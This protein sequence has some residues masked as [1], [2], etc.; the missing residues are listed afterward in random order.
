MLPECLERGGLSRPS[1]GL[2]PAHA[3]CTPTLCRCLEGTPDYG[4]TL[5]SKSYHNTV[6]AVCQSWYVYHGFDDGNIDDDIGNDDDNDGDD[7][8]DTDNDDGYYD[9]TD[10]ES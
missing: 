2:L 4:S 10:D 1:S 7:H 5:H 6:T 8:D 9:D 3:N